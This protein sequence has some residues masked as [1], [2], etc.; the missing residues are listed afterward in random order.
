[1]SETKTLM[2]GLKK[3][4]A[5]HQE[6]SATQY[7]ELKDNGQQ[8]GEGL[9]KLDNVVKDIAVKHEAF[10]KAVAR[11][12][13]QVE[14]KSADE[15]ELK[16]Y[17]EMLHS[18]HIDAVGADELSEM[19]S[20]FDRYMKVGRDRLTADEA[21]SI[22]TIID[23][24][25]GF[26]VIPQY[27]QNITQKGFD[28]RGFLSAVDIISSTSGQYKEIIDWADYSD[29]YY[30]NELT[31]ATAPA[32][33]E[34][35]KEVT[36]NATEQI[37]SK[38]FS[39]NSLEDSSRD[40][41]SYVVGKLRDGSM[42]QSGDLVVSG[43]G[44]DQPRGILTY[45]AGTTYGTIQQITSSAS[46]VLKWQDVIELLPAQLKDPY[47]DNSS[48]AMKRASF[49]ALLSDVDGN[50]R[51]QIGNQI[52]FFSGERMSLSILGSPVVF[53]PNFA[54]VATN[55]LSVA[56]GDFKE[57]YV[58]VERLG[59]S[60]LRDETNPSYVKVHLRRRNDGKV[61]NFEATKILKIQ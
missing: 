48:Y 56:F 45:T 31:E 51:F 46:G 20:S 37:Y 13:Q 12:T 59:F 17:N 8:F 52:N 43:T 1:M 34:A 54:T 21:K 47:H 15:V 10:E 26:F 29:S 58:F 7:K 53:D 60:I 38:K 24:D 18:H 16:A 27:S 39:R 61:R 19:K 36:W 42:R 11:Q 23:P 4:F 57:T 22:N 40:I 2:E 6:I 33:G 9:E 28:K 3:A 30:K 44:S 49:Y 25:G 32:D 5:D 50:A 35:F 14:Q 41:E 55:G